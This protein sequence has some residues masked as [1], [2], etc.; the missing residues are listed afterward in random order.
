MGRGLGVAVLCVGSLS[1]L[2]CEAGEGGGPTRQA[3]VRA[4]FDDSAL[5]SSQG[6]GRL[7]ALG[8]SCTGGRAAACQSGACLKA[9][10]GLDGGFFCSRE[11]GEEADCPRA[12][13]CKE[14]MP[15]PH[16]RLCVPPPRWAGLVSSADAG[17]AP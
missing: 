3:S 4:A 13:Q 17:G 16:G 12:W 2:G 14:V 1:M 6:P 9:Q 15:G 10:P 7:R 11:C 5:A 8:E